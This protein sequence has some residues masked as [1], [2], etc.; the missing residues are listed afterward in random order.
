[1]TK[2]IFTHTAMFFL[3]G[4]MS[5]VW[6]QDEESEDSLEMSH[7][8]VVASKS[9][10][11]IEDVVGSV[12]SFTADDIANIQAESFDD[13]LRFQ[14]NINMESTGSRFQSS[15]INIRGI[16]DNR[17]AIEVDGVP[18]T[19]QFDIGSFSNSGRLLPE[20]DLIKHVEILNGPAS[21]LYGSD[22]IGGVVAITT[23]DP[24]ELVSQTDGNDFYKLRLG[25]EGKNHGQVASG[26]AAWKGDDIG[27]LVSMTHRKGKGINNDDFVD[28]E[29]DKLDWDSDSF[30]AKATYATA[31]LD[32]LT[33]T[34]QSAKSSLK[35]E[36]NALLGQGRQFGSSTQIS[37]DDETDMVRASL[38]YQFATGL[39]LF[40]DNVL[41]IYYLDSET[42]QK[43][44]DYRSS[45][46]V[47]VRQ[48]RDFNYQQK[49]S[50][51]E[52]NSF[53]QIGRHNLVTGIDF[54]R[55]ET[56]EKRDA[57]QTN[58]ITGDVTHT[59]LSESFPLRDFPNTKTDEIGIFV[60]DEMDLNSNWTIVPAL[61]FDYY[62]L[63]PHRDSL[64][65][66]SHPNSNVVSINETAWSPKFGVLRHFDNNVSAYAQYVRGF[67]A[68]PFED[69]NIGLEIPLFNIRAIPNPDLESETSNGFELGVRQGMA[70]RHFSVAVFYTRY[71]DFIETKANIGTDPSG[72]TLIQ[73]RNLNKAEIYGFELSHK[74]ELQYWS[75]NLSGWS[76]GTKLAVTEGNNLETDEPIN[77][78]SPAQ[79][80]V[81]LGWHNPNEKWNFNLVSTL[82][83]AKTRV[84]ETEA[85]FFKPSGYVIFDLLTSYQLT[86][87]SD[88]RFGIFNVTDKKYWRWQD[89]KNLDPNESFIQ[90]VTRP[91]RNISL[92]FSQKW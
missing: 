86:K 12:V 25:Y 74:T 28:N 6:S 50:G 68:P 58:L 49:I 46:G 51:M 29:Q 69:A 91:E 84:D 30:F 20:I 82:T 67:R 38:E 27:T 89:V 2:F 47:P 64:Y 60:Q 53:A 39:K 44:V 56:E 7:M 83:K 55:T 54:S 1:M 18:S 42:E 62:S 34:L 32:L 90:S 76:L 87:N 3:V 17:V 23:W 9:P 26:L 10:R 41:R 14:P 73:S 79:A 31:D 66:E 65:R 45:R 24:A 16:G 57:S 80:I 92:S 35:S 77:S 13:L 70:G 33:V 22:A 63:T 81:D 36:N 4:Y 88:L 37:G 5:T 59:L 61:R 52:L 19:D 15:S 11:L 72:T 40:E 48:N 21:T 71:K 8:V 43:T 78:I 85:E 75:D